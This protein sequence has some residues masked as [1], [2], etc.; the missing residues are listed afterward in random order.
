MYELSG[1]HF[2]KGVFELRCDDE[3]PS[4]FRAF[5][6]ALGPVRGRLIALVCF[7]AAGMLVYTGWPARWALAQGWAVNSFDAYRFQNRF[8]WG[9]VFAGLLLYVPVLMLR[10]GHVSLSFDRAKRLFRFRV[11]PRWSFSPVRETVGTFEDIAEMRVVSKEHEP[12][13]PEG[14]LEI[15]APK[16][17]DPSLEHFRMRFLTGEQF[18]FFPLNLSKM[19][20]LSPTGDWVDP[21][22]LPVET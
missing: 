14:Y 21:E 15:R 12:H 22:T 5:T 10:S 3:K 11:A 9:V 16:L 13:T 19:T 20:G 6:M 8:V 1:T 18:K 4:G 17:A 7:V 2:E